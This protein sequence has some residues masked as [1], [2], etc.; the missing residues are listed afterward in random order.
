MSISEGGQV[1]KMLFPS[2]SPTCK[3]QLATKGEQAKLDW[4]LPG[5]R[6]RDLQN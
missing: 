3:D 6:R 5:I 1:E 4:Q 2:P